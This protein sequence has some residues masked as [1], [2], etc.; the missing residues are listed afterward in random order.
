MIKLIDKLKWD[1]IAMKMDLVLDVNYFLRNL[2][3]PV[4][5]L[6]AVH[7]RYLTEERTLKS[8]SSE[9]VKPIILLSNTKEIPIQSLSTEMVEHFNRKEKWDDIQ[10]LTK[11]QVDFILENYTDLFE[12]EGECTKQL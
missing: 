5:S 4:D 9:S 2:I 10:L 7:L 12:I 6:M 8:N 1:G 3:F 11:E